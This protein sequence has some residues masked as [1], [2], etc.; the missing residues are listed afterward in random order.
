MD[1]LLGRDHCASIFATNDYARAV[2][3]P[4][5]N[6]GDIPNGLPGKTVQSLI[7]ICGPR[8]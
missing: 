7:C 4:A 6:A 3:V 1:F 8:P 5:G 2:C